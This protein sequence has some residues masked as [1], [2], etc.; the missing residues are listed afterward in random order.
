MVAS[1]NSCVWPTALAK[2]ERKEDLPEIDYQSDRLLRRYVLLLYYVKHKQK[3]DN[4]MSQE[5]YTLKDVCNSI[6]YL[7]DEIQ[8]QDR[9]DGT[10]WSVADGV[11]G[12]Y[13]MLEEIKD[14]LKD[15]NKNK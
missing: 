6:D 13:Y 14:I 15:M 5:E 3:G 7:G 9:A 12:I 11:S 8:K 4:N 10:N 2:R 1:G